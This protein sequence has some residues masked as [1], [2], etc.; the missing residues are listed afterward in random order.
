MKCAFI[1]KMTITFIIIGL[2]FCSLEYGI[3]KLFWYILFKQSFYG[4]LVCFLLHYLLI[5]IIFIHGIYEW[6]FPFQSYNLY[7]ESR[8]IAKNLRTEFN[9]LRTFLL[10][11]K[12]PNGELI[13]A[14]IENINEI[15]ETIELLL[16]NY[17][18]CIR[19]YGNISTYQNNFY[20]KLNLLNT[21][22][23]NSG[24]KEYF[25][26]MII[27]KK[28]SKII[29][30]W[31]QNINDIIDANKQLEMS[32][33]ILIINWILEI[34]DNF[35]LDKSFF[36]SFKFL[37][38]LLF[39]DTF[40]NIQYYKIEFYQKFKKYTIN[41]FNKDNINYC[42][43]T[44][45][46]IEIN[47]NNKK[48]FFFCG[49][50]GG[51][52]EF[53]SKKK[54]KFYLKK[55]IDVLL[56]N[57][58]GYGISK[59]RS[60]FKNSKNDVLLI[61]DEVI[62]NNNYNKIAVCG[63]SIGGIPAFHLAKN[64]KIDLLISD[65]N[66][67]SINKSAYCFFCGRILYYLCN[68]FLI[69]DSNTLYNF[70]NSKCFKIILFSSNDFLIKSYASISS[71]V[72]I[73]LLNSCIRIKNHDMIK[74]NDILDL[75]FNDN[76]KNN[77]ISS[78]LFITEYYYS[79]KKNDSIF[80]DFNSND[81]DKEFLIDQIQSN[82]NDND[83]IFKH[84]LLFFEPFID[85]CCNNLND[86]ST[87]NYFYRR[88]F[89]FIQ[90]FFTNFIIWGIQKNKNLKVK[91]QQKDLNFYND[92]CKEILISCNN[93]LNKIIIDLNERNEIINQIIIFKDLL[94]IFIE[95]LD[96]LEVV[97]VSKNKNNDTIII[98]VS[99]N[100]SSNDLFISND[101]EKK[102]DGYDKFCHDLKNI[103]KEIKLIK[104][105]CGHNGLMNN[106]EYEQYLDYLIESNFIET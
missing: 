48:L 61:F 77:F 91:N 9:I 80:E 4:F 65:R 25:Q 76:Q 30:E 75:I 102:N 52:Y 40:G 20:E 12:D 85:V 94:S 73:E 44:N 31:K 32:K 55:G 92:T 36:F 79:R 96:Q 5:R 105:S 100:N 62:K 90:N 84:L 51:P 21:Q 69:N 11:L 17:Q 71:N 29:C 15:F 19:K 68:F 3:Y 8:K 34:F 13:K 88:K 42:I 23:Q 41:E 26:N 33:M 98:P 1:I 2:L 72:A 7:Y 18:E 53:I 45:P 57:Y 99:N 28:N 67:A 74:C 39:N 58:R 14:E 47:E 93:Q 24:F 27:V 66:F 50:N 97:N 16:N 78:F 82:E 86:L 87:K 54:I 89:L 38:T 70:M 83:I 22:M 59:G 37:K 104:I 63:Y 95:K 60:T 56:W 6:Q 43:I 35:I 106:D 46:K 103:K 81:E 64:R 10:T 49:P 101:E